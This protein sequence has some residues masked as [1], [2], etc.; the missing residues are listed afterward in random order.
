MT[1]PWIF[2][3]EHNVNMKKNKDWKCDSIFIIGMEKTI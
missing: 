2:G 1:A 3:S